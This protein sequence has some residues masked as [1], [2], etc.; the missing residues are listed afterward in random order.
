MNILGSRIYFSKNKQNTS[1]IVVPV[2]SPMFLFVVSPYFE[3]FRIVSIDHLPLLLASSCHKGNH[4]RI[5]LC[6]E[7]C[8]LRLGTRCIFFDLLPKIV[9]F[10]V[11]F[12]VCTLFVHRQRIVFVSLDRKIMLYEIAVV[13]LLFCLLFFPLGSGSRQVA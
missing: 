10:L 3:G 4:N 9:V 8:Q 12:P 5:N 7:E 6:G 1:H 13:F 2:S 11:V